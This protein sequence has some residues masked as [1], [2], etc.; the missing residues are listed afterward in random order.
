MLRYREIKNLLMT[1][2][3]KMKANDRLPSRLELCKKLDTTRM[4]LDKAMN[5]LVTEGVL[6]SRRGD[7]TYVAGA[8]DELSI[9]QGNWGVIVPDVTE[10]F[11]SKIVRGVENVA[12]SYGINLILC[13]SDYDFDKQEQY[14]KRL[15]HSGVSGI[16]LVP[17][18]SK[19]VGDSNR[20]QNQLTGLKVPFVFCTR[21]AE[22]IN[23]PVVSSNNFYGGYIAVKHLLEQGY[24]NIAHISLYKNRTNIERTNGSAA[25]LLE[26]GIE[27]NRKIIAFDDKS[28]APLLG[29]EAMQRIL[30]SGQ[31]VDAVFCLSDQLVQGVYKAIAEAGLAVSDDI[32][33][34]GYEN[35]DSCEKLIPALSSVDFKNLEIG[36]KAAE[37]LYKQINGE[38]LTEFEIYLFQPDLVARESCLGLNKAEGG[39]R[40]TEGVGC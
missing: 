22:G 25:A 21:S 17:I 15:S 39:S 16:I 31:T 9:H 34:I 12:Q 30:A 35:S 6:Y 38:I 33:V 24:R 14:I 29:Y 4:T 8:S 3:A 28:Q 1:E 40:R 7:G 10:G 37:V 19:G 5:E 2:I 20:L 23:A 13:N 18:V 26:K 32:G 27:I 11:H 36:A